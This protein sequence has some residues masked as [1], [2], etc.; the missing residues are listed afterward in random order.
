MS[1]PTHP[2]CGKSYPG[3]PTAGHCSGCCETFIGL[4]AFES[5]RRGEHGVDRH[6]EITDKHW[7]DDRGS[8]PYR[9]QLRACDRICQR[10][11][12]KYR[13]NPQRGTVH[14]ECR[15]CRDVG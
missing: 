6:C 4:N 5:H 15:D 2:K 13:V 11:G 3:G 1:K 10:C 14:A 12:I 8:L 7:T 9:P